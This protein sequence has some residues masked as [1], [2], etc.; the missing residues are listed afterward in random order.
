ML[1]ALSPPELWQ[2]YLRLASAMRASN[3][4]VEVKQDC[5]EACQDITRIIRER[6]AY[7]RTYAAQKGSKEAR[8]L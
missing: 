2:L 7:A 5:R 4:S 1:E 6:K 8:V 3:Q